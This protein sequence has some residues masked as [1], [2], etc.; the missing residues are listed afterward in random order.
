[1][2]KIGLVS[3]NFNMQIHSEEHRPSVTQGMLYA[4]IKFNG[5]FN[6]SVNSLAYITLN[7]KMN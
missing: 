7:S 2:E 5:L 3:Q 1:M 6:N 4:V